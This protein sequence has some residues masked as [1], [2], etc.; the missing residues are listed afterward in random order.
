MNNIE[1]NSFSVNFQNFKGTFNN[2]SF[3]KTGI[4]RIFGGNGCGKSL[5]IRHI[6]D[7]INLKIKTQFIDS[8][9]YL[10]DYT[11]KKNFLLKHQ[12]ELYLEKMNQLIKYFSLENHLNDNIHNLSMGQ[13]FKTLL[14]RSFLLDF[15]VLLLDEVDINLDKNS[16]KLL[17]DYL[18]NLQNDK[19]II[20][21]SH[22]NHHNSNLNS[23]DLDI[24]SIFKRQ[25]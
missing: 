13:Y 2:L 23:V 7:Q 17:Y 8:K 11:L 10:F 6:Y 14:I 20:Y 9:S 3:N 1:I 24:N 5:L 15:D 18:N 19:L 12:D 25:I 22:E 4:Y 16:K 21:V